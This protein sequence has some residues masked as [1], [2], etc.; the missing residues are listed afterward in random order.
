M[1]D[2]EP[3]VAGGGLAN[4]EKRLAFGVS[5][6]AVCSGALMLLNREGLGV[7]AASWGTFMALKGLLAALGAFSCA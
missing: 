1:L 2:P 5:E 7:P 4:E 6:A 3:L